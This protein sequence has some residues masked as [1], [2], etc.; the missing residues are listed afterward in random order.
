METRASG[1]G[2][3][4]CRLWLWLWIVSSL[5]GAGWAASCPDG[6]K[7][8]REKIKEIQMRLDHLRPETRRYGVSLAA[9][10]NWPQA[11]GWVLEALE[12]EESEVADVAQLRLAGV[13]CPK[14]LD[15]LLGRPGLGH[16]ESTVRLRV[17]E[18]LG[19]VEVPVNGEQLVRAMKR[20][21]PE[22]CRRLLWSL[23]RLER[24]GLLVGDRDRIG[25]RIEDA[26]GRGHAER[27][28]A[29]ALAALMRVQPSRALRHLRAALRDKKR[30]LLRTAAVILLAEQRRGDD[31]LEDFDPVPATEILAGLEA[32]SS[33]AQP[34]VRRAAYRALGMEPGA[35]S[36]AILIRRLEE[37][38]QRH[39][40]T[41]LVGILRGISG[42]KHSDD[43]RPWRD[44]LGRLGRLGEGGVPPRAVSPG[45]DTYQTRVAT[46]LAQ[47]RPSTDRSVILVDLS[48]SVWMDLKGGVSRKQL[49]D[50]ELRALLEGLPRTVSFNLIPYATRPDPWEKRMVTATPKAV[51]RAWGEFESSRLRG[52]GDVWS[53][54][55]VALQDPDLG[56]LLI[57]TDGAPTGGEH[58]NMELLVPLLEW[59]CR[60]R[61]IAVDSVLI[62]SAKRL[63]IFWSDL[64]RRTGG[65]MTPV[66]FESEALR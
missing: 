34:C 60:W 65:T 66:H 41:L 11:W 22:L 23:E 53:A 29:D 35:S 25:R 19:R 17:A 46:T 21:D 31:G 51:R 15:L 47:L 37:E 8:D 62:D 52:R 54:V 32:A 39:L 3:W 49:L 63:Q 40:R 61:G 5:G 9:E 12:D 50:R 6:E 28:R 45:R 43:P 18:A 57:I 48:G 26:L 38:D 4:L 55:Q 33:D 30:T 16:R 1:M 14:G 64:A 20:S 36:L 58:S 2:A 56:S 27:V 42:L 44:W 7:P 10:L 24:R 13:S 59:E